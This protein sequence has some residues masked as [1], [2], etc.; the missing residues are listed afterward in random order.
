MPTAERDRLPPDIRAEVEERIDAEGMFATVASC[1][2]GEEGHAGCRIDHQ[3]LVDGVSRRAYLDDARRFPMY[4]EQAR[5]RGVALKGHMAMAEVEVPAMEDQAEVQVAALTAAAAAS[6]P[7]LDPANPPSGLTPPTEPYAEYTGTLFRHQYGPKTMMVFLALP[8][9]APDWS[10]P[11]AFATLNSQ[12]TTTSQWFYDLSYGLTWFGPKIRFVGQPNQLTVPPLVV[13]PVL[14]LPQPKS[15]Y[16][17]NFG[18]YVSDSANALRA[19]GGEWGSNGTK[20]S[21]HFD[22]WVMMSTVDLIPS[23]GVAFPGSRPSIGGVGGSVGLHEI[24]HNWGVIHANSWGVPAGNQ[25]RSPTGSHGEYGDGRDIMGGGS[26]GDFM[27]PLFLDQL[28]FIRRSEGEVVV[29]EGDTVHRLFDR[30]DPHARNPVSNVRGVVIPITGLGRY[31]KRVM[32]GFAH[33]PGPEGLPSRPSWERTAVTVH[34]GG[35]SP[36]NNNHDGSHR[37]DTS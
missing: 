21:A 11:P 7:V 31:D 20:D 15:Y 30:L 9:D 5:I 32:L 25:P 3:T 37:L 8:S 12:L 36:Q 19:L 18:L 14:R 4:A 33:T 24:G 2:H 22:R 16:Y 35:T 28:G 34:S 10:S 17:D 23:T 27:N 1:N 6:I 29:A 26:G 13:T